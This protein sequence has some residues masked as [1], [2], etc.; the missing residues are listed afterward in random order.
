LKYK[1]IQQEMMKTNSFQFTNPNR[2]WKNKT[3][4]RQ[5]SIVFH[6]ERLQYQFKKEPNPK[7]VDICDSFVCEHSG[8]IFDIKSETRFHTNLK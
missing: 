6:L 5:K 7:V 1:K 8:L 2:K 4:N 3:G